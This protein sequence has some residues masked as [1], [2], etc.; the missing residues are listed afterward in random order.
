MDFGTLIDKTSAW[1][2]SFS[3][4]LDDMACG[5]NCSSRRSGRCSTVSPRASALSPWLDRHPSLMVAGI[6]KV[7]EKIPAALGGSAS[8]VPS[9]AS[10]TCSAA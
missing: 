6:E 5:C 3:T 1:L 10:T 2:S 8:A 4:Q 9:P 7:A